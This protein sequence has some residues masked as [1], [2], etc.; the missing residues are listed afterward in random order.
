MAGLIDLAQKRLLDPERPVVF[1]HTG[2]TA[3]LFAF[4]K[5]F[6]D[7]AVCEKID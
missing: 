1:L 6:N 2:G 5:E 3:A 7:L 4:E